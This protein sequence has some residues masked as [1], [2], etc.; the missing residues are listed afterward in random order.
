MK[1]FCLALLLLPAAYALH[2]Q[3]ETGG[4]RIGPAL[5]DT[6]Q[7]QYLEMQILL[8]Q[9]YEADKRE[10]EFHLVLRYG[11]G[12][13]STEWLNNAMRI[14]SRAELLASAGLSNPDATWV[15]VE[16]IVEALNFMHRL[17]WELAGVIP[18]T[19]DSGPRQLG[20]VLFIPQTTYLLK[21]R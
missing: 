8:C 19:D 3:P 5:L 11:Q 6:L 14:H 20:P 7:T 4:Y 18:S 17:G 21:R 9:R 1:R 10:R 16:G 2:A 12:R 13:S 15:S